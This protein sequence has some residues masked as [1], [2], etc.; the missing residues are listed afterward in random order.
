ML[1]GL[2]LSALLTTSAAPTPAPRKVYVGIFLLDVSDLDLKAGRFKGDARVWLKW[3]GDETPPPVSFDNFEPESKE[4]LAHESDGDWRSVQWRLQGT[5]RGRF[6]VH[7]FPFDRQTLPLAFSLADSDGVLVPDLAASGMSQDFSITGWDYERAFAARLA[8]RELGSDLGAIR[9][10]GTAARANTVTFAVE[11]RRPFQPYIMKF[12]LPLAIILLMALLALLL[13]ISE[14]EVRSAMGVTALLSCIAFHF[15]QADSLPDVPYLVAADK[16]FIGSYALITVTLVV[17]VLGFNVRE[18]HPARVKQL[19]RVFAVTVPALALAG[20]LVVLHQPSPAAA[21]PVVEGPTPASATT[22]LRLGVTGMKTTISGLNQLVRR[23]L[24]HTVASGE[25]APFLVEEAPAMTNALVRLLPDGGMTVRWRLKPGL[26]WSDGRPLTVEQLRHAIE[27]VPTPRRRSIDVVDERTVDVTY[28]ERRLE[29]LDGVTIYPDEALA[30]VDASDGGVSP[31]LA[32]NQPK[33][34]TLGPYVLESFEAEKGAVFVRNPHFAGARPAFERIEATAY[35]SSDELTAALL[36]GDIDATPGLSSQGLALLEG[37]PDF[38]LET[39]PGEVGYFLQPDLSVPLLA[40][41]RVREALL[42]AVDREALVKTLAPAPAEVM[43]ALTPALPPLVAPAMTRD[44]AKARLSELGAAGAKLTLFATEAPAGT[45][46]ALLR[47][48][49]VADLR[50]AGVDVEV[51]EVK[52]LAQLYASGTHGGLLFTGRDL[53]VLPRFFNVPY[54]KQVYQLDQ[55]VPGRWD[56]DDVARW[57]R[58]QATLYEER[59]AVLEAQVGEAWAKRLPVL[60]LVTTSRIAAARAALL[61][62][63]FGKAD[64]VLWNVETWRFAPPA[65]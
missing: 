50:A 13:P 24:L 17:T 49:L 51:H 27:R 40:D 39:Q 22:T 3:R 56:A 16:L 58:L 36:A 10:E 63:E 18:R 29:F 11:M 19:D 8:T 41:V 33:M 12:V 30:L 2:L 20:M 31:F 7:D 15:T 61:G 44:E 32:S 9:T 42:A 35:P 4:E 23:G 64:S 46:P 34:P 38:H 1:T 52:S 55:P 43:R 57:S 62:F 59:R 47:D 65:P 28:D 25:R 37:R 60:P 54:V 5:F 14:L 21:A 48:Q 6:P 53:S 45:T 26:S